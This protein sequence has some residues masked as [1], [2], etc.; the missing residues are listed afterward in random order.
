MAINGIN[1]VD[2]IARFISGDV[3]CGPSPIR[4]RATLHWRSY[5][6]G[7]NNWGAVERGR[8]QSYRRKNRADVAGAECGEG[9][10]VFRAR[11]RNCWPTTSE[12]LGASR[13]HEPRAA[14]ARPGQGAASARTVGPGV[15]V[16]YGGVRHARSEG[17]EG[18]A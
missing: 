16:V 17:G 15:R 13:R 4:R 8:G 2:A 5:D 7:G 11:T 3:L 14:L 1:S 6:G 12:I 9:A 18:A 10:S